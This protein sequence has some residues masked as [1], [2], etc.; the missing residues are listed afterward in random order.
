M[1]NGRFQEVAKQTTNIAHLGAGRFAA[2]EFPLPP[3]DEQLR[4]VAK[5]DELMA[6]VDRLA[7]TQVQKNAAGGLFAQVAVASITGTAIRERKYMKPP[8]TEL[9]SQLKA[10]GRRTPTADAPLAKL[11]AEQNDSSFSAK[12]LW[13]LSGLEIDAFYR[14]LK[15]ELAA[16]WIE[17]P[18][19][20]FIKEVEAR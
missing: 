6:L 19:K 11:L 10:K 9:V 20:A 12:S 3:I 16:G 8:M 5:V 13:R 1:R 7:H 17:E 18:E 4:I 14:Q 15:T 2:L